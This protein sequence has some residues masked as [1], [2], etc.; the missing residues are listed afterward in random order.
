[1]P[2]HDEFVPGAVPGFPRMIT[3]CPS[4]QPS[5][6][7]HP[8]AKSSSSDLAAGKTA[9]FPRLTQSMIESEMPAPRPSA[10]CGAGSL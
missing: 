10:H 4:P 6:A 2:V 9:S 1:M 3:A 8:A 5:G 7:G